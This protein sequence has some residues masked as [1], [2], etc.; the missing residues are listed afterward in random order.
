MKN[1]SLL[2]LIALVAFGCQE[3][4]GV[5][6]CTD[7]LAYNFNA[8]AEVDNGNCQYIEGCTD[9]AALNFNEYAMIMDGSCVYEGEGGGETTENPNDPC[10]GEDVLTY[11]GYDY[12][13]VAVGSQCWMK[14]NLRTI[15]N[16]VD[17]TFSTATIPTDEDEVYEEGQIAFYEN[18]ASSVDLRGVLYKAGYDYVIG[19]ACP[20]GWRPSNYSDIEVMSV[21]TNV[22]TSIL[23]HRLRATPPEWDGVDQFNLTFVRS[24]GANYYGFQNSAL[25]MNA[26]SYYSTF[27]GNYQVQESAVV[28]GSTVV[29]SFSPYYPIRCIKE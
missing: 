9:P 3:E 10:E 17:S 2:L 15:T 18:D 26:A 7:E 29:G 12:P 19:T 23:G 20:V 8:D 25:N 21:E 4:I 1:I 11:H 14:E 13:L 6:G 27:D 28:G 16:N 24:P 22:I 5:I